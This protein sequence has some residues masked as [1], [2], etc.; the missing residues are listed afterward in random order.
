M[1]LPGSFEV[2]GEVAVRIDGGYKNSIHPVTLRV[3][4]KGIILF[5]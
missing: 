4:I 1:N 2:E 3:E 5:I